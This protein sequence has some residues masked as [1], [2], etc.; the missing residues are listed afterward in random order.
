MFVIYQA[1][2]RRS[3]PVSG[4]CSLQ[5][6]VYVLYR[7]EKIDC[8]IKERVSILCKRECLLYKS[9][10]VY[11]VQESVCSLK[12]RVFVY[13]GQESV[14][15]IKERVFVCKTKCLLFKRKNVY[16]VQDRGF[17][18]KR[19]SVCPMSIQRKY[20]FCPGKRVLFCTIKRI[21]LYKEYG[22]FY[23]RVSIC[24]L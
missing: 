11:S 9:K 14:C 19:K 4:S 13:S 10:S 22:W 16:S 15:Y 23:R 12:E 7:T 24:S 21:I 5:E 6:K 20:L 8:L 17:V 3:S 18:I 1:Y 2:F